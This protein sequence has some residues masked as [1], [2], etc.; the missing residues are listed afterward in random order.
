MSLDGHPAPADGRRSR[1][2]LG[3]WAGLSV[4]LV[5]IT[6]AAYY[7]PGSGQPAGQPPA[8]VATTSIPTP[9]SV[10]SVAEEMRLALQHYENAIGELEALVASDSDVID[11]EVASSL[12]ENVDLI[13]RA[14]LESR[15]A[16]ADDP[17]SQPVRDS[18]FEALRR[19]VS[20]L[21]STV[22]L[23]NEMR[24]GD[25]QGAAETAAGLGTKS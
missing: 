1:R 17:T 2:A 19:K 24:Q 20:V 15:A 22:R 14:I 12:R 6:L 13:D 3:Q 25:E 16:L 23:I 11:P 8:P 7:L 4:A 9:A 5:V 10:D 21:Q 18:L